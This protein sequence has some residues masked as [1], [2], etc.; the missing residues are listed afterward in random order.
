[1]TCEG[2]DEADSPELQIRGTRRPGS[3]G[4]GVPTGRRPRPVAVLAHL[5][6]HGD[7]EAGRGQDVDGGQGASAAG[8]GT[9]GPGHRLAARRARH[10]Q[11]GHEPAGLLHPAWLLAVRRGG[12][13]GARRRRIPGRPACRRGGQRVR[14][15]RRVQ[16][17]PGQPVRTGPA[18]RLARAC[19]LRH[20]G[21]DRHAWRPARRGPAGR[22][23]VRDRPRPRRSARGPSPH[24]LRG[25]RHRARRDRGALPAGR[26]GRS[27]AV[28]GADG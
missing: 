18:R 5:H 15:A 28:R 6:R 7:D 26:A 14:I 27:G 2:P 16:L 1:M 24:R 17:D 10:L 19:R 9:Q 25:P 23:G 4:S 11:E 13:G 8:P 12:R 21:F 22:H 20:R 3:A